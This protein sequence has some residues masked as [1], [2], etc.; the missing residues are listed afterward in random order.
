MCEYN[1]L[2]DLND[3]K[4]VKGVGHTSEGDRHG[5]RGDISE[6]VGHQIRRGDTSERK[7]DCVK[8][9]QGKYIMWANVLPKVPNF[10]VLLYNPS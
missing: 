3:A 10:Q 7:G 2:I 5:R 8:L 1:I 9:D 4:L 6:G